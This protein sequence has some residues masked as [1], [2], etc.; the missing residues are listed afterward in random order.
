MTGVKTII[1]CK[2]KSPYNESHSG[3]KN[4]ERD[5]IGLDGSVIIVR[6][7][8]SDSSLVVERDSVREKGKPL[9]YRTGHIAQ[10]G[11]W[12]PIAAIDAKWKG[13]K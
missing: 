12:L 3:M 4:K 6:I 10:V 9:V 5:V 8:R 13:T 1:Y 7:K 11:I 2:C